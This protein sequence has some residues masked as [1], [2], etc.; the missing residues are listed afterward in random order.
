MR[1]RFLSISIAIL[2]LVLIEAIVWFWC[3]VKVAATTEKQTEILMRNLTWGTNLEP[4]TP[5]KKND[6]LEF[7]LITESAT[8][9]GAKIDLSQL[10]EKV[11]ITEILINDVPKRESDLSDLPF[12]GALKVSIRGKA[13]DAGLNQ[14]GLQNAI[15][16]S[17]LRKRSAKKEIPVEKVPVGPAPE[18]IT[19][20]DEILS[21]NIDHLVPLSGKNLES[22]D[23]VVVGEKTFSGLVK[24]GKYYFIIPK[25]TFGNGE[26]FIGLYLRNGQLVPTQ[27]RLA[28]TY[29]GNPINIAAITPNQLRNEED[30]YVVVQGNGFSKMISIQ[31]SN[32][33]IFKNA[34]FTVIND[35]VV[36]IKIPKGLEPGEYYFNMMDTAGIYEAKNI[37]FT[38]TP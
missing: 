26:F 16:L 7:V 36:S 32:N 13:K 30:H 14:E 33:L 8:E 19:V 4:F 1:T 18:A 23:R 6:D 24:D 37:Q 21:S 5:Y 27:D 25:D 35:N 28:F 34:L 22:I 2:L 31:L 9:D 17:F 20:P 10:H 11:D 29:N 12:E 15:K 38:V 3:F